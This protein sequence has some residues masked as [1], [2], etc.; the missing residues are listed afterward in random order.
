MARSSRSS[1]WP[2]ASGGIWR[3]AMRRCSSSR[4]K[5]RPITTPGETAMPLIVCMP[6]AEKAT[7]ALRTPARREPVPFGHRSGRSDRRC[8]LG[9]ARDRANARGHVDSRT[10]A[11]RPIVDAKDDAGPRGTSTWRQAAP[12]ALNGPAGQ[13]GLTS[14]V[15]RAVIEQPR[16]V[17]RTFDSD[18]AEPP[19]RPAVFD[20]TTR[21]RDEEAGCHR[22]LAAA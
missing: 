10:V 2:T 21:S 17:E 19:A 6:R 7:G 16:G 18:V 20:L 11:D 12:K 22:S 13:V 14:R 9:G 4:T 15:L 8:A 3:R 5:I 1:S